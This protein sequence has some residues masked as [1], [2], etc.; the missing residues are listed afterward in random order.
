MANVL[1]KNL[2]TT[3]LHEPKGA[4]AASA[5][6]VYI[7]DGAGSGA[8]FVLRPIGEIIDCMDITEPTGFLFCDGDTLGNAASNATARAN[9]DTVDLFNKLWAVGDTYATLVINDSTGTPSTYGAS[10]AADYGANKAIALP[11]LR[12]RVSAGWDNKGNISRLT[13]LLDGA[14]IGD[15]GGSETVVIAE[16]N[17]PAHTHGYGTLTGA[18]ASGGVNHTHTGYTSSSSHSHTFTAGFNYTRANATGQNA[19]GNHCNNS[20][21]YTAAAGGV[22]SVQT[23]GASA[24]AHTHTVSMT[25]GA[26]GSTGSGTGTDVVQPTFICTKLIFYGA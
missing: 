18:A 23:Y 21:S 6:E 26:T 3:D 10:A 15:V 13:S 1:H 8:W 19:Q 16:A 12:E 24:Y 22:L 17:L 25:G 14:N 5:Y 2:T 7:A 11:D 9:A 20:V 4:D